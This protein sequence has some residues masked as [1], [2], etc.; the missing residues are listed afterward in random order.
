MEKISAPVI[1][2]VK[3]QIFQISCC[4]AD[5]MVLRA[6]HTPSDVEICTGAAL[7]NPVILSIIMP[8]YNEE[9]YLARSLESVLFQNVS[10]NFEIIIIDDGSVDN[11]VNIARQY[12]SEFPNIVILENE[13]NR[14]KGHSFKRGYDTSRGIYFQV[15]DGD[16]IIISWDKLQN[17]IDFLEKNPDYVAVGHNSLIFNKDRTV[18]FVV[19]SFEEKTI[20]YQDCMN[21]RFYAHTSALMYRK[22]QEKLPEYFDS[23]ELRGDSAVFFY[24]VFKSK[25]KVKYFPDIMSIYNYTEQ[26]IWSGVDD[27]KKYALIKAYFRSLLNN[28][29]ENPELFEYTSVKNIIERIDLKGEYKSVRDVIP[30]ERLLSWSTESSSEIYTNPLRDQAFRGMHYLK[31]VDQVCE[32]VGRLV[33]FDREHLIR[34]RKFNDETVAILVSGLRPTG[35]GVYSE[36]KDLVQLLKEN[37]KK[38]HILSTNVVDTD[39]EVFKNAFGD[40]VS[41]FW[42]SDSKKSKLTQVESLIDIITALAPGRIYPFP[43]HHDCVMSASIQRGIGGKIVLDFVFDHGLSLGVANSSIDKII[44]KT[45]SQFDSL[46]AGLPPRDIIVVPPFVRDTHETNKYKPLQNGHIRTASAS[47][48]AYKVESDYQWSYAD[49][50]P[51]IINIT[52]GTHIHYGPLSETYR[53]V[54]DDNL[55]RIGLSKDRFIHIEWAENLSASLLQEGVDLFIAPF[56]IASARTVIQVQSAGVPV[57]NHL[58]QHSKLPQSSDFT[59]PDQFTWQT[60]NELYEIMGQLNGKILRQKSKLAREYFMQNNEFSV[61]S[62]NYFNETGICYQA[63]S[64]EITSISDLSSTGLFKL[65]WTRLIK[66]GQKVKAVKSPV[67]VEIT[68]PVVVTE[69]STAVTVAAPTVFISSTSPV[70]VPLS[71]TVLSSVG[72]FMSIFRYKLRIRTRVRRA[73]AAFLN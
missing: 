19:S 51:N 27:E 9:K 46:K 22:I 29:I 8:V 33:L 42:V 44:V 48:R 43:S 53:A 25:K 32:A 47:A 35:G 57:L 58:T 28:V 30:L 59:G 68:R 69:K 63:N 73:V 26:G 62:A 54:I 66:G 60:P 55:E 61:A 40:D 67:S 45:T 65:D 64:F 6:H 14:G 5:E 10:F 17:Q 12:Q 2:T 39:I 21:N 70:V 20:S 13:T 37:G 23:P 4:T 15:L 38:I 56:P 1:I 16:D 36:L 24:H 3:A 52:K 49:V 18:S 41:S 72:N 71:P 11:T 7:N 34:G 31:L 50:I